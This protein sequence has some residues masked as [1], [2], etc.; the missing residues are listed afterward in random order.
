MAFGQEGF[1]ELIAAWDG[2]AVLTH[3]DAPT[4]AWIFVAIHDDT[5]GRAV[6]GCRMRVYARPEEGLRDALRLAEGMTWKWAALEMPFGGGKSVL[7]VPGPLGAEARRGLLRRFGELL[8]TLGGVYA[9]GPDLGIIPGDMREVAEVS[10]HVVGVP[11][12]P[13]WPDDPGPLTAL[14]VLAGIRAALRHRRGSTDLDGVRVLVEG[15]GSVGEPLARRL[16]ALGA[17]VL[18]TD[19]NEAKAVSLAVELGG[20]GVSREI[21]YDAP[22]DVYA[23]CAVGATLNAETIP[24]LACDV[25][26]G[27]ADNQLETEDDAERLA[28]RGI[29]YAPDFMVNAGGAMAYGLLHLGRAEPGDLEARIAGIGDVLASVFVEAAAAGVTPLTAAR[30]RAGRALGR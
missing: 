9:T 20:V 19:L 8:N 13:G 21:V 28:A 14:G 25:V 11:R 30:L 15:V 17:I 10:E 3:H 16:A 26:A 4:G 29:L 27:S 2:R 24:K 7:A 6:G 23:P 5:L 22:C 18:L 12:G 1:L